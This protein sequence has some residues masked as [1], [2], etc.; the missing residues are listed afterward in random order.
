M[1]FR[2][3][4]T[5]GAFDVECGNSAA[6]VNFRGKKLLIDCGHTVFPAL[7]KL[8]NNDKLKLEEIEY[9]LL[10]HLHDDHVGSI[11]SLLYFTYYVQNRR[12]KVLCPNN[13]ARNLWIAYLNFSMQEPEEYADFLLFDRFPELDYMDTFGLHLPQMQTYAY[14][15]HIGDETL[16]YSGDIGNSNAIFSELELRGLKPAMVF[17]DI[18]F[19][20]GIAAHVYYKDLFRFLE[21][22]P[23][24]GYH[25][26]HNY[27]PADNIIPLAGKNPGLLFQ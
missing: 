26:N 17:H 6:L 16:V 18:T 12:L 1:E 9:V 21:Q 5:G 27:A 10:T 3:I 7:L 14:M 13:T 23:V 11:S 20:P 24:I 19:F 25:H 15:L 8:A 4:G 22:Y 2:F